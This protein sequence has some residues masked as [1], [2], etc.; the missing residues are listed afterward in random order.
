MNGEQIALLICIILIIV[1]TIKYIKS[2]IIKEKKSFWEKTKEWL[3]DIFDS[4]F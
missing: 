4:L 1:F 3:E 2:L